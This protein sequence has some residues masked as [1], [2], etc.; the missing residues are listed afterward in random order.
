MELSSQGPRSGLGQGS[1]TK[2]EAQEP[3][4]IVGPP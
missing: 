1:E 4:H 3:W 2:A